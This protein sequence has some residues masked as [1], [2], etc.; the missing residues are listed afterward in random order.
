MTTITKMTHKQIDR[1][2]TKAEQFAQVCAML[3][4]A[5]ITI[6][7]FTRRLLLAR[8]RQLREEMREVRNYYFG[9]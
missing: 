8:N 5:G 7:D 3:A 4:Q 2:L 6:Q 9:E 1:D